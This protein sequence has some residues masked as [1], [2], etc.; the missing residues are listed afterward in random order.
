M[1]GKSHTPSPKEMPELPKVPEVNP[2]K[3]GETIPR[4]EEPSIDIP[5]ENPIPVIPEELP[6]IPAKN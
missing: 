4:P 3:P 6:Q 2:D 5:D 1:P